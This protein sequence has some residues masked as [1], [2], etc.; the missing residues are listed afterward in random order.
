MLQT[1]TNTIG[2]EFCEGHGKAV[3]VVEVKGSCKVILIFQDQIVDIASVDAKRPLSTFFV[4]KKSG[5]QNPKN[6][7]LNL[8]KMS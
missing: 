8:K 6:I 2:A 7:A 3:D 5:Y 4:L 1:L